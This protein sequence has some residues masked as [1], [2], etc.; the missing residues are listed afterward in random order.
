MSIHIS[1][2]AAIKLARNQ[3]TT[4]TAGSG[5]FTYSYRDEVCNAWRRSK[6]SGYWAALSQRAQSL[7]DVAR[8]AQGLELVQYNGGAWTDYV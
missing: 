2:T 7:I 8:R 5:G 3:I 4:V 1:R 6:P